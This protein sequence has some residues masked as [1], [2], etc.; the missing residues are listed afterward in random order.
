M[1][2]K[3]QRQA[4]AMNPE[5]AAPSS[6]RAERPYLSVVVRVPAAAP[7]VDLVDLVDLVVPVGM[8]ARSS[9]RLRTAVRHLS[10]GVWRQRARC[11]VAVLWI[12]R[13]RWV[14]I[15]SQCR[16]APVLAR[17]LDCNRRQARRCKQGS[18]REKGRIN[19]HPHACHIYR[20]GGRRFA[21]L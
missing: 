1:R 8:V 3:R 20:Q 17:W 13:W 4:Y 19:T 12:N 10:S 2:S 5:S 16:C 6:K 9:T 11:H 14:R 15:R 18:E 7:R 21:G